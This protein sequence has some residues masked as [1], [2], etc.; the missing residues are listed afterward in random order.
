MQRFFTAKAVWLVVLLF[1]GLPV[2]A[3]PL[4]SN[5]K[6]NLNGTMLHF[7]VRGENPK[8]PY[9]LILHGGPG[10]SAHMFY[11][12]GRTLEKSLNVVYLDQRGCG[13]SAHT[14]VANPLSPTPDETKP[15]TIPNLLR[16]LEAVRTFLKVPHWFVLGHSWGGMLGVEYAAAFPKAVAGYIHVDGLVSQPEMQE[17]ILAFSEEQI[18]K[19][20]VSGDE[21]RHAR[22][23]RLEPYIPYARKLPAGK[24][25]LLSCMQFAFALLNEMYYADAAKGTAYNKQVFQACAAYKLPPAAVQ[26]SNEPTLGL[27]YRENYATRDVSP[28]LVKVTCRTLVVNGEQDGLIPPSSAEK[29]AKVLPHATLLLMDN[30][31]HFPFAEQPQALTKAVLDFVGVLNAPAK[32]G[33]RT[34]R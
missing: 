28:L 31:G 29:T 22:A 15:Y 30:C 16:D 4:D 20:E 21:T 25:R 14:A 13:E 10:F 27:I 9:L 8:N 23:H 33:R 7:R 6:Q 26:I 34:L 32:V 19:D 17:A 3:A 5:Y 18:G 24:E 12:W 2:K 1:A 11:P